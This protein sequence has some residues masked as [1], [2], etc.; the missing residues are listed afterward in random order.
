MAL[1]ES[2]PAELPAARVVSNGYEGRRLFIDAVDEARQRRKE[3]VQPRARYRR[4]IDL[5][6]KQ[7]KLV[8]KLQRQMQGHLR[9]YRGAY[10]TKG[11]ESKLEMTPEVA[12][13]LSKTMRD[14]TDQLAKLSD[15]VRDAQEH[16]KK[17][18]AGLSHEELDD[19]LRLHLARAAEQMGDAEKRAVLRVWFGDEVTE[20]LLKPREGAQP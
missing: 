7:I 10:A 8:E 16:E 5:T 1:S 2:K 15:S 17:Q 20:V 19:V 3:P 18:L 11:S 12:A 9:K 14:I 4:L 6:M 13:S